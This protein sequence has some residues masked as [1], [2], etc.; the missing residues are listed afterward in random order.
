MHE[1]DQAYDQVRKFLHSLVWKHVKRYGGDE[2]ECMSIAML[3]FTEAFQSFDS[4][5]AQFSTHVGNRVKYALFQHMRRE[6]M[7][8]RHH[9]CGTLSLDEC[10][11]QQTGILLLQDRDLSD[12][13]L[14]VARILLEWPVD[15]D[16]ILCNEYRRG[17]KQVRKA[18][19]QHL[20]EIGWDLLRVHR[21]FDEIREAL[22]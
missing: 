1:I 11:S 14:Q 4:T 18:L 6:A 20:R 19:S 10:Q 5:I 21:A 22:Q 2:E 16:Y 17:P 3:A 8:Y 12:D 7:W 13:A 15:L 9:K